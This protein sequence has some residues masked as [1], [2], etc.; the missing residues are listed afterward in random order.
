MC[1]G[2]VVGIG[3]FF[4]TPRRIGEWEG[5]MVGMEL[6]LGSLRLLLGFVGMWVSLLV[7]RDV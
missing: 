7:S 2:V 5:L 6:M 4:F 3:T 1:S